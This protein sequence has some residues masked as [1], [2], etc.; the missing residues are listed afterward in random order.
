MI[1]K[2][3]ISHDE[4]LSEALG[5][6]LDKKI[7]GP[8]QARQ[9]RGILNQST[10]SFQLDLTERHKWGEWIFESKRLLYCQLLEC[11]HPTRAFLARRCFKSRILK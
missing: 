5:M 6:E 11:N 8:K 3:G 9:L 1:E 4:K 7:R 10:S 2:G